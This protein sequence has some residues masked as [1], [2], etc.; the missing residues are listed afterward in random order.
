MPYLSTKL[1]SQNPPKLTVNKS[2]KIKERPSDL[3]ER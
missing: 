1:H 3:S 2:G